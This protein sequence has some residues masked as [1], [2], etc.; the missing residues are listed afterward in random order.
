MEDRIGSPVKWLGPGL[1]REKSSS[2]SSNI[3]HEVAKRRSCVGPKT[4]PRE[5]TVAMIMK[6]MKLNRLMN[7]RSLSMPFLHMELQGR[8]EIHNVGL[9]NSQQMTDR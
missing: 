4:E 3:S 6:Q 8:S 7:G 2:A 1:A 9:S 5:S